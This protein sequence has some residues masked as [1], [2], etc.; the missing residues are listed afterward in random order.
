MQ[1]RPSAIYLGGIFIVYLTVLLLD[2]GLVDHGRPDHLAVRIVAPAAELGFALL[3][4]SWLLQGESVG[5]RRRIRQVAAF[6]VPA[7]FGVIYISQTLT[8]H[9]SDNFITV[10]ALEN[11]AEGRLV[12]GPLFYGALALGFL[13]TLAFAYLAWRTSRHRLSAKRWP[14]Y[15]TLVCLVLFGWL[16][17]HQENH[18]RME[19]GYR[20]TPTAALLHTFAKLHRSRTRYDSGKSEDEIVDTASLSRGRYPFEKSIIYREDLPYAKSADAPA[21][22]PNVIVIFTEGFSARV[23]GAY[24][25]QFPGLTPNIDRLAS[26]ALKVD[27]Y[28]NH[29]AATYRGLGGQLTSGYPEAGGYGSGTTWEKASESLV[30]VRRQ[31][32]PLLLRD[33]GYQSYFFSPHPDTVA[34]N[35]MLRGLG[36]D[37]VFTLETALAHSKEYASRL[38]IGSLN[39]GDLFSELIDFMKQREASHENRPMFVGTY[40]IGTHAFMHIGPTG[41]RYGDGSNN[42]L[43]RFHNYDLEFGKFLDYFLSSSYAKNT[44]LIFTADHATFPE[45]PFRAVAGDNYKPYFVDRIPLLI[46][47]PFHQ[48][49]SSL[50]ARGRTSLSLA[51]TI[52]QLLGVRSGLN[53]FV[54]H[55]LFSPK[56]LP[57]GMVAMGQEFF[58]TDEHGVYNE[59]EIPASYRAD[60]NKRKQVV[61]LYYRLERENRIFKAI[62]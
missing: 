17:A 41:E 18:G 36:F 40:D 24:G 54:G 46:Y 35:D 53:S 8:L 12:R 22:L 28:Y 6:L 31:S 16:C 34:L 7:V 57:F 50:D 52:M 39:D 42:V 45:P 32:L 2:C 37:R 3:L 23:V 11:E 58:A 13:W 47:D 48:L 10:L 56:K 43:D 38:T 9:L 27:N 21:R 62:Q 59:S 61:E 20:Q 26:H 19:A 5:I 30:R 1:R 51:P 4:S 29:T 25:G 44:I 33:I 14:V 55:T 15:G 49:P 60:F